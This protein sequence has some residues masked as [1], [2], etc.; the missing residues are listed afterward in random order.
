[1]KCKIFSLVGTFQGMLLQP[2]HSAAQSNLKTVQSVENAELIAHPQH[3]TNYSL[4]VKVTKVVYGSEEDS[5]VPCGDV[6]VPI[7]RKLTLLIS[8]L[9]CALATS[10]TEQ[11]GSLS[12]FFGG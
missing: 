3:M 9:G 4:Q 2:Y 8:S 11:L 12:Q 5:S 6:D 10:P 7:C 1:M